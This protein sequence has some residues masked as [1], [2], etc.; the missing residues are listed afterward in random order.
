ME[1]SS[2]SLVPVSVP[3]AAVV[4]F[5]TM[6]SVSVESGLQNHAVQN[7]VSL[8]TLQQPSAQLRD[9]PPKSYN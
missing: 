2:Q 5:S 6:L 3:I 1:W 9:W 8:H 7:H 4:W